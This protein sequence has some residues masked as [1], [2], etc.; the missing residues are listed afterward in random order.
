MNISICTFENFN[1]IDSFIAFNILSRLKKYDKSIHVDIV[2]NKD[3][4][5]SMN[6]VTININKKITDIKNYE[7]IIFGSS[8]TTEN[9]LS[10]NKLISELKN[11][12]LLNTQLICSQCS[13]VLFLEKLGLINGKVSTDVKTAKKLTLR[14]Y[15]VSKTPLTINE[16]IVSS[17]GCLSSIYLS[18]YIIKKYF[19]I[20]ILD[21]ILKEIKCENDIR[22]DLDEILKVF[23]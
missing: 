3:R 8:S 15:Q 7:V 12:P 9:I 18:S 20:S 4:I 16:N 1:E 14:N 5:T 19:D 13:G 6:G 10:D 17:G 21:K 2:S 23:P 22:F 11:I